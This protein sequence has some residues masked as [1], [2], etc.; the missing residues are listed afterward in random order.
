MSDLY[1]RAQLIDWW[2]GG[3]DLG[4]GIVTHGNTHPP[5]TLLPNVGLPDDLTGKRVLDIC[6]WDGFMSFECERRGAATVVATDS[7]AWDRARS[8]TE[9]GWHKT[10]RDGFDLAHQAR[11]S[12]V[13]PIYCDVLDLDAGQLGTFDLVLF[14]GVI[15]HMR[16]PLLALEKVAPLVDGLLIVESH[17]DM[18]EIAAP[19]MRFYPGSEANNDPTNWWGPNAACLKA[20]LLDVGFRRVEVKQAA[21]RAVLHAW[22]D[23]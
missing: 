23:A 5:T 21:P 4:H 18:Q 13:I 7:F 15:Y 9:T 16:H 8:A 14:L 6:A 20:M 22:R 11:N 17:A 10:G 3:I 12:K 2:H 19:A 1:E